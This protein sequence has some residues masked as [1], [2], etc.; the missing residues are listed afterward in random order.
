MPSIIF[1]CQ[2]SF[3]LFKPFAY[4]GFPLCKGPVLLCGPLQ[5]VIDDLP[6]LLPLI[7]FVWGCLRTMSQIPCGNRRS[8]NAPADQLDLVS[9]YVG[10]SERLKA[11]H[12]GSPGAFLHPLLG[13][14]RTRLSKR[15]KRCSCSAGRLQ[16]G[17]AWHVPSPKYSR[18]CQLLFW[19][20]NALTRTPSGARSC[21]FLL[22][23]LSAFSLQAQNLLYFFH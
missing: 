8:N 23:I 15:C 13:W 9:G 12:F 5:F 7:G 16:M 17:G 10:Q 21:H 6:P 11:E 18:P 1:Y 2:P 14:V 19:Q 20:Y 4:S 3:L 22:P